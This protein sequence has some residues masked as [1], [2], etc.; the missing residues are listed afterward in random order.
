MFLSRNE[1]R[2]DDVELRHESNVLSEVKGTGARCCFKNKGKDNGV[3]HL[4]LNFLLLLK[5]IYKTDT[6]TETRC[7]LLHV[8]CDLHFLDLCL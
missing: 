8:H 2:M 1:R 4:A 6:N 7:N 5:F 3:Q